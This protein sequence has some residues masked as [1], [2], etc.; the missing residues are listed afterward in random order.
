VTYIELQVWR[1][2]ASDG[3][4]LVWQQCIDNLW[5]WV[6]Y[7]IGAMRGAEQSLE[8]GRRRGL[9]GENISTRRDTTNAQS[10]KTTRARSNYCVMRLRNK[11]TRQRTRSTSQT[12]QGQA[13]NAFGKVA[14]MD[15]GVG[16]SV[17]K[18]RWLTSSQRRAQ[19]ART[20]PMTLDEE[21]SG[22]FLFFFKEKLAGS[23][24]EYWTDG[25]QFQLAGPMTG[26]PAA[27]S[28]RRGG[29]WRPN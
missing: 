2:D 13:T 15:D 1:A 18:Q 23:L 22:E 11:R 3:D 6:F 7:L 24:Q 28:Q 12:T 5:I 26:T 21:Y 17:T 14:T 9:L 20:D 29:R 25:K 19:G 16:S 10:F 8:H 27:G 4:S